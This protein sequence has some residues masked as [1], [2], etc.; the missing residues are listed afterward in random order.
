MERGNMTSF[1]PLAYKITVPS[2]YFEYEV[3]LLVTILI[4]SYTP[5]F[6]PGRLSICLNM[7][8]PGQVFQKETECRFTWFV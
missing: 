4:S 8:V 7:Q 2:Q 6:T 1:V 3:V 5:A